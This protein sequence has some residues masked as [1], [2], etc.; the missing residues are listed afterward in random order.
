MNLII[1]TED[2]LT[3]VKGAVIYLYGHRN[4]PKY[5]SSRKIYC[6]VIKTSFAGLK[7]GILLSIQNMSGNLFD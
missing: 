7:G 3:G 6:N 4:K 2:N 5:M 1:P